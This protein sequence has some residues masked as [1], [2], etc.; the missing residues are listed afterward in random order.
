M[1]NLIR[2]TEVYAKQRA[3]IGTSLAKSMELR[4][5]WNKQVN[6]ARL[7]KQLSQRRLDSLV[8]S[9]ARNQAS[10]ASK[11]AEISTYTT[12]IA[13]LP[14]GE[15]KDDFIQK[16]TLAE[17][18][19]F[20]LNIR[21]RSTGGFALMTVQEDVS[22]FENEAEFAEMCIDDIINLQGEVTLV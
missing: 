7:N 10:I 16:K 13:A 20:R 8:A 22:K 18:D 5:Y 11:T 1:G 21:S 17:Q 14:A 6:D 3:Y 19:L 9:A 12:I 4:N 15:V 2:A